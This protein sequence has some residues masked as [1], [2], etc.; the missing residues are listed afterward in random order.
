MRSIE[1]YLLAWITGA[2]FLGAVLVALVTYLVT[3]DEMNEAFDA[4]LQNVAEAI[5]SYR[6]SGRGPDVAQAYKPPERGGPD[7][8]TQIVALIWNSAG[9]R[10]YASDPRVNIPF[11]TTEGLARISVEGE[12]WIVYTRVRDAVTQAAQR[13]SARRE[14][15]GEAAAKLLA[16]LLVLAFIVGGLLVFALR[17]GLQPLDRAARDVAMRS[18]RSLEPI[19]EQ[20]FPREIGPLVASINDLMSRLA[21][22]FSAQ[23]RFLADAAHELRTPVTALRLQLQGLKRAP[24][25]VA[26]AEALADLEAGIERSQRLVEQLMQVARTEPDGEET[27]REPVDLGAVVRSV[28]AALSIKAEHKGLDLGATAPDGLVVE[29]DPDQ[30]TVLLN[31]LVENAIRYTPAGGV[32]DV[33]AGQRDGCA[34]LRVVDTGPGIPESERERVF[35]RFYRI[36]SGGDPARDTI[37]SGLGLAIVKAIAQR[38]HARISLSTPSSGQGLEVGVVFPRG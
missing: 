23:R 4:D 28:V 1:R 17:R 21:T 35:D 15:A 22:A 11:S 8:P 25:D 16:P 6:N 14:M 10:F 36:D 29:G 5:S 13:V 34:M 38:H 12:D 26:R 3:L 20:G 32:I 27:R 24:D 37:G 31:N 18:A 30:L 19:P 9:E 33:E 2:L 7:D